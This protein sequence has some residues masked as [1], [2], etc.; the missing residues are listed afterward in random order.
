M[1]YN[2]NMK[3]KLAYLSLVLSLVF[4]TLALPF[5]GHAFGYGISSQAMAESQIKSNDDT[6]TAVDP[7]NTTTATST[8]HKSTPSSDGTKESTTDDS[9][10]RATRLETDKKN[11]KETV[12]TE[13]KTRIIARCV[14]AQGVVKT[15]TTH[16]GTSS[17][18]RENTYGEIISDLQSVVTTASEKGADVTALQANIAALQAKIVNFKTTNAT[19]QQALNDLGQMDCK[20]DPVAFR[21]ALEVARV[22]QIAV[23]TN[24]K[25]IRTYLNDTVKVTLQ[26]LK[27]TLKS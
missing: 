27:D 13:I 26:A 4:S 17:T 3:K 20:T 19:F 15:K 24:A 9:A 14:S 6:V 12:T 5:A 2:M 11:L 18:A 8:E 22:D 7:P 23:S 25:E 1:L 10:G 16:N 21:A